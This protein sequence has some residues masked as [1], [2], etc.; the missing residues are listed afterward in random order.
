MPRPIILDCDPGHDDAVALLLALASPELDLLAVTVTHGNV[1]LSR[2]LHNALSVCKLAGSG[3][4][5]YAGADRPL[6]REALHA[7]HVHGES[8]LGDVVL[9]PPDRG[10]SPGRAAD[11]LIETALARPGEL[12]LVATGPLT[13]VALALRLEP[14]LAGTLREIVLMGGSAGNGNVTPA[15]EFNFYA[16]PHAARVVFESGARITMFG[17]NAT[18]QVPVT[19]KRA[20][21]LRAVNNPQATAAADMLDDYLRRLEERGLGSDGSLHDPCTVAY[22]LRPDLFGVQETFVEI[23]AEGGPDFGRSLCDLGNVLGREPNAQ[24]AVGADADGVYDLLA[25]ALARYGNAALQ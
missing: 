16:D 1:P 24:V 15:A 20:A 10:P 6:L 9:P 12:T 21:Q 4:P 19:G 23:D 25:Q 13:N 5:V 7:R 17:L 18:A 3:V 22:L 8:G 14:K 2:T 11:V